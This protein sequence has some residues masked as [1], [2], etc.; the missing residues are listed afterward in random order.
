MRCGATVCTTVGG[1]AFALLGSLGII[2]LVCIVTSCDNLASDDEQQ[3]CGGYAFGQPCV[4]DDNLAQ[5]HALVADGC[6]LDRLLAMESCPLQFGCDTSVGGSGGR[7]RQQATEATEAPETPP[8][9][10]AFGPSSSSD[11]RGPRAGTSTVSQTATESASSSWTSDQ[12][13]C[14]LAGDDWLSTQVI[15]VMSGLLLLMAT[16]MLSCQT[17]GCV[18]PDNPDYGEAASC[19]WIL[20]AASAVGFVGCA[21]A[22]IGYRVEIPMVVPLALVLG[23]DV[24]S[25]MMWSERRDGG[26]FAVSSPE[27]SGQNVPLVVVASAVASQSD[28]VGMVQ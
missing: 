20:Y 23:F 1:V 13:L 16:P 7:R 28:K 24:A 8:P 10:G 11:G 5:C 19:A 27:L 17:V 26:V 4:T 22:G 14:S 9:P 6:P 21:I 3:S 15:G 18:A 2:L 12:S 25:A